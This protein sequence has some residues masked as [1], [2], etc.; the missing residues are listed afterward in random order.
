M[1]TGAHG[2]SIILDGTSMIDCGDFPYYDEASWANVD[3][4]Y[5][6]PMSL[7]GV[8]TT[9]TGIS[10]HVITLRPFGY[11]E[12]GSAAISYNGSSLIVQ[13]IAQ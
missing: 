3:G 8:L 1:A 12:T 4:F 11:I 9:P 10:S 5:K 13:E 2:A 6:P 7:H